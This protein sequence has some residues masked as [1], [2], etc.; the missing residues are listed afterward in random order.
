MKLKLIKSLIR[1]ELLKWRLILRRRAY[2]S[3][4]NEKEIIDNFSKL[5]YDS[6]LF[7]KSW[8]NT[9]WM[10]IP[11]RK[12]PFDLWMYQ[13]IIYKYKPDIIIEAGTSWGGSALFIA[14]MF[15]LVGNGHIITI[16]IKDKKQKQRPQHNRITYIKGSSID[17]N[18]IKKVKNL[19]KPGNKVMVVLD[20]RHQKYHVDEEIK[21]YAPLVSK[22]L[23]LIVEDTILNGNPINPDFGPGPMESVKEFIGKTTDFIIDKDMENH[24][25][26][27]NRCGYLKR[28][29]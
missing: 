22:G 16:D 2:I 21:Y 14:N 25:I 28:V 12:C 24:F 10:G 27:F 17:E 19:I 23:Y 8:G 26:T 5:Y 20:S 7:G 15:D 11:V 4:K 9:K 6:Y 3:A 29:R 13:E 18:T 1:R